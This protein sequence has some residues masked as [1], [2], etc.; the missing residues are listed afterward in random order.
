MSTLFRNLRKAFDT[1]NY[2]L[3]IAKVKAY[4]FS[5]NFELNDKLFEKSKAKVPG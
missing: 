3:I 5:K 4:D 1:I 2:D